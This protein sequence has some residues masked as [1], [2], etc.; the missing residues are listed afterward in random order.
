MH[1]T[2]HSWLAA[3]FLFIWTALVIF[4]RTWLIIIIFTV[5][6][7][8]LRWEIFRFRIFSWILWWSFVIILFGLW[9][10]SLLFFAWRFLF[11]LFWLLL[12]LIL[13][14]HDHFFVFFLMIFTNDVGIDILFSW[15]LFIFRSF[16]FVFSFLFLFFFFWLSH[17][18][19]EIDNIFRLFL[20]LLT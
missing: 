6:F 7:Y 9:V 11:N 13:W 18:L 12:L 15:S 3:K 16:K 4:L 20:L 17:H 19:S 2:L 1:Y 14:I 8:W 5:F 10:F